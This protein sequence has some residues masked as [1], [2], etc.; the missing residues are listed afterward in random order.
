MSRSRVTALND[1]DAT[2]TQEH[3]YH[4]H[5]DQLEDGK[6]KGVET[7]LRLDSQTGKFSFNKFYLY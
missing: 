6:R 1:N 7:R 3:V 5:Q 4:Q 2:A